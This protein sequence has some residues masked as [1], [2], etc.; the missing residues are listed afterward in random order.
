MNSYV[1]DV[2]NTNNWDI[3]VNVISLNIVVIN[4]LK[5]INRVINV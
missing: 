1:E 4:V 2:I 3:N 5:L